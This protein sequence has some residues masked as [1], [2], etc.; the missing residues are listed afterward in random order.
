MTMTPRPSDSEV[1]EGSGKTSD[2][3][4]L[5]NHIQENPVLWAVSAAFVALCALAAVFYRAYD[6]ETQ[7]AAN[8]AYAAALDAEEPEERVEKLDAITGDVGE[9]NAEALYMKGESAYRA[10]LYT[11]AAEAYTQ[12]REKHPDY[13]FTPDAVEGL[14]FIKENEGDHDAAK[15]IYQEILDTWPASFAARRQHFNLGR[16]AEAEGNFEAARDAYRAQL[17]AFPGSNIANRAQSALDRLRIERPEIFPE[18]QSSEMPLGEGAIT[19]DSEPVTLEPGDIDVPDITVEG[20]AP[21]EEAPAAEEPAAEKPETE[22]PAAEETPAEEPATE[23]TPV[24]EP[25]A[26]EAPAEETP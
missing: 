11:K 21:A 26:E 18:E 9:R 8:S 2:L 25:V 19:L 22:E 3:R 15:A 16:V 5:L 24:E 13:A 4:A 23:E 6:A 17:D 14:G 20:D 1:L 7:Q 10:A 12:L